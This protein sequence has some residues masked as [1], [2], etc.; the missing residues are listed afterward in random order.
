MSKTQVEPRATGEW[1]HRKALNILGRNYSKANQKNCR[2]YKILVFII[3]S[4]R[5]ARPTMDRISSNMGIKF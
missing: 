1:S 4:T 2:T 3:W 5:S